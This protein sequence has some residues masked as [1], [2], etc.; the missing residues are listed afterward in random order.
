MSHGK[1][2]REV[3]SISSRE[4]FHSTLEA[5]FGAQ[6]RSGPCSLTAFY[7]SLPGPLRNWGRVDP[8]IEGA[9]E[10]RK[11]RL[12]L[13]P[14]LF[15]HGKALPGIITVGRG[16]SWSFKRSV[17]LQGFIYNGLQGLVKTCKQ[18]AR[19]VRAARTCEAVRQFCLRSLSTS[20]VSASLNCLAGFYLFWACLL[21]MVMPRIC[22]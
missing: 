16:G 21:L 13:T 2:P 17:R 15:C 14:F 22:F 10:I 9:Q 1:S 4:L 12:R 8:K 7:K 20:D 5:N 3:T 6:K 11:E 19:A 18:L